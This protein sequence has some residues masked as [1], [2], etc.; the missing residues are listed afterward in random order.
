MGPASRN[1]DDLTITLAVKTRLGAHRM[2]NLT[3][4]DVDTVTPVVWRNGLIESGKR[5]AEDIASFVD[6]V[7]KIINN[8]QVQNRPAPN[9]DQAA[10]VTE[11]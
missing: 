2:S 1:I 3:R 8:L 11:P 4:L 6:G 10:P 9:P 7:E 5:R